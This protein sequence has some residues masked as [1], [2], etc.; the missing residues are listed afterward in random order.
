MYLDACRA[1]CL[2]ALHLPSAGDDRRML[3]PLGL[4]RRK[5]HVSAVPFAVEMLI[6]GPVQLLLRGRVCA[7]L[8][9][10]MHF[11]ADESSITY[12]ES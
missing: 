12:R 8:W 10:G 3:R 7:P 9:S 5:S 11:V 1:S 6:N 4:S 2:D